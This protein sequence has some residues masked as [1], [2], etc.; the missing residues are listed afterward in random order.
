MI[1]VEDLIES[2]EDQEESNIFKLGKVVELFSKGTAKVQFD[3]EEEPSEKEYAYLGDYLPKIDDRVLLASIANTYI[4]LGKLSYNVA[5]PKEVDRYLFDEKKVEMTKGLE[6][7]SGGVEA[8]SIT[9]T[10]E[11]KTGKTTLGATT[12]NGTL[13]VSGTTTFNGS[14]NTSQQVTTGHFHHRGSQLSFFNKFSAI[15]RRSVSTTTSTDL[16]TIRNTLN[17][18]INALKDYGL[19]G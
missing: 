19:I 10:G 11:L 6:V 13:T 2:M 9:T 18:L 4:I 7:T 15:T 1:Y 14:V 17:N 12:V 5:P 16:T 3:G 8:D